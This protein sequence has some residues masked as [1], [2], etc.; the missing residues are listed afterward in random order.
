M[1]LLGTLVL[2]FMFIHMGD[3]WYKMKFTEQLAIVSYDGFDHSVKDLYA[4]VNVAFKE[5][6]IVIVYLIG[7]VALALHLLHGFGSAF[8]TLGLRHKKYTPLINIIGALFSIL[9]PL[10]FAIIPLYIYFK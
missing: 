10:G 7:L 9:V 3:F 1:A 5:L 8:T 6:W 2:A 4:R